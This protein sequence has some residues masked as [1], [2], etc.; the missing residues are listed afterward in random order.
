MRRAVEFN[1]RTNRNVAPRRGMGS[2]TPGPGPHFVR[3][4]N[5]DNAKLGFRG[6]H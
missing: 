6:F 2:L 5:N 4:I 1:E 3:A